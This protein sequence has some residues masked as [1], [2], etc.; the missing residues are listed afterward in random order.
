VEKRPQQYNNSIQLIKV[1]FYQYP[2]K[3]KTGYKK[4]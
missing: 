1:V 2:Y 4:L 3:Q